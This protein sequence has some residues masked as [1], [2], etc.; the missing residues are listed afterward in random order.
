MPT[1]N[2]PVRN[3][4][5]FPPQLSNVRL[6]LPGHGY[7]IAENIGKLSGSEGYANAVLRS[8]WLYMRSKGLVNGRFEDFVDKS[9]NN[10]N[11]VLF[12]DMRPYPLSNDTDLMVDAYF[13]G[14]DPSPPQ[15]HLFSCAVRQ[16][17][18]QNQGR[19]WSVNVVAP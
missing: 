18:I 14:T 9:I 1:S 8:H 3:D 7:L 11:Q 6:R 5:V 19:K 4:F 15:M 13:T 10:Y 2:K 17:Y 12:V 16:L